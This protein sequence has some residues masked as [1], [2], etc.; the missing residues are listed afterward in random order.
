M[1]IMPDP[2]MPRHSWIRRIITI[3]LLIYIAG[4]GYYLFVSPGRLRAILFPPIPCSEPIRYSI[5]SIDPRF[6]LS[7]STV[8]AT[9]EQVGALWSESAQKTLFAYDP[10]G[11][12]VINFI[13]DDRQTATDELT[14]LGY[15]ISNDQ[16]SYDSLKKKYD[17]LK[18]E[19]EATKRNIDAQKETFNKKK[20]AYEAEV[21]SW[22]EKGGAPPNVIERLNQERERLQAESGRIEQTIDQYNQKTDELNSMIAVLKRIADAL[23]IKV[24][25][26]NDIGDELGREFEEGEYV[27]DEKG[28]EEIN[29]YEFDSQERLIRVLMHEFGHA[30][31]LDHVEDPKAVMYYLNQEKTVTLSQT[32][33]DAVKE[34]CTQK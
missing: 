3:A 23:N 18:L 15:H 7:T 31:S 28:N 20:T 16:A 11:P 9:L 1:K 19:L 21:I 8:L 13:Y 22:N 12:L 30:L 26:A 5:G 34:L 27:M 17:A 32:D 29:I 6:S 33:I 24:D 10:K 25:Q 2:A 14:E 4:S